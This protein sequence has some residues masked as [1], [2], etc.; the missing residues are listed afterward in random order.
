MRNM[1]DTKN[2][3]SDYLNKVEK[4]FRSA[5]ASHISKWFRN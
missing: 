5:V 4:A 3:A 2:P 1:K